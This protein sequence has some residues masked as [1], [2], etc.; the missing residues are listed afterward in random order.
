MLGICSLPEVDEDDA[1]VVATFALGPVDIW[2]Q[3]GVQEAFDDFVELYFALHLDVDV[4]HDLLTRLGLPDAV[5]AHDC[6]VS[7]ARDL[8]HFYVRQRGDR[9]FVELQP[10]VLLVSDV[11][12]GSRK[13]QVSIYA[14]LNIDYGSGFVDSFSL[15]L[16]SGLVVS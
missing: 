7:L 16:L 2:G 14:T 12:D 1:H 9:L 11:A 13:V 15:F 3:Q 4:V 10:R 6:E 8:V 5:A